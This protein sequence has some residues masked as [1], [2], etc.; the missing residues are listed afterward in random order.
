MAGQRDEQLI[1]PAPRP[2]GHVILA[3]DEH[4]RQGLGQVARL[5]GPQ[6]SV[7]SVLGLTVESLPGVAGRVPKRYTTRVRTSLPGLG[8]G[9]GLFAQSRGPFVKNRHQYK[10]FVGRVKT[11]P[12]FSMLAVAFTYWGEHPCISYDSSRPQLRRKSGRGI[13]Q[14]DT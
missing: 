4:G 7:S 12:T 9:P 1:R 13:F 14:L 6:N 2:A 10:H 3:A 11:S 5:K 8:H